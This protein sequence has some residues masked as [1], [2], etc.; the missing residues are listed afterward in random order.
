MSPDR[1][2][3]LLHLFEQVLSQAP[4]MRRTYLAEISS[5]DDD[6]R[7]RLEAML[8]SA[9]GSS[10]APASRE[11]AGPSSGVL[12]SMLPVGT[13]IGGYRVL[14][15]IARGG[16]GEVYL[17]VDTR[18]DRRVALK[19]L[20]QR[21]TD[22]PERVSRFQREARAA[23][24]LTHPNILTIHDFGE[25]DGRRFIASEFVEGRTL[26]ELIDAG[27]STLAETLEI[28]AQV[29]GALAAAHDAGIVHRDIK[30]ENLMV[31]PDG[32]VKVLDFGLAKLAEPNVAGDE[33]EAESSPTEF[34][35]R[36]GI[37]LGTVNYM[38][39][40]QAR[41]HKVDAR[42]DLFSLGVVL[43]ELATGRRPFGGVTPNHVLVAILDEEPRPVTDHL[44]E[45]PL[46]LQRIAGR[47][48]AKRPEERYGSAK[49][50][51]ADLRGMRQEL[52]GG[53]GAL[54]PEPAGGPA[55]AANRPVLSPAGPVAATSTVQLLLDR[56]RRHPA[57]VAVGVLAVA[58]IVVGLT[59]GLRR[60]PQPSGGRSPLNLD[61]MEVTR[62]TSV[63]GVLG[64][65]ISADGRF[66]VYD[67][68]GVDGPSL[69]LRDMA[70][71]RD[72]QL[73]PPAQ[74]S[75]RSF[76]LSRD[77]SS[78]FY[79]SEDPAHPVG[80]VLYRLPLAGGAPREII[81]GIIGM[82]F[83]PDG[84]RLLFSRLEGDPEIRTLYLANVDRGG[85]QAFA[86]GTERRDLTAFTWSPDAS[87]ITYLFADK[88]ADGDYWGV[89]EKPVSGGPERVVVAHH[90]QEIGGLAWLPDRSGLVMSAE[91]ET[92]GM[93]QL[94]HL[95][96]PDGV[97]SRI[98]RDLSNYG[99]PALTADGSALLTS[100]HTRP[101]R[102]WVAPLG[103]PGHARPLMMGTAEYGELA[104]T[105]DG[106]VVYVLTANGERNLWIMDAE[107]GGAR[108]L[109]SNAH[110]NLMPYVSPDGRSIVFV[111]NRTGD[112]RLW[113]IDL[114]GGHPVQ[115][116][117]HNAWAPQGSADGRW[118]VYQRSM[119]GKPTVW[120]VPLA[121]GTPVQLSGPGTSHPAIS[122]DGRWLA[123]EY[124]DESAHD[125]R[126]AVRPVEGG[127]PIAT[128]D[129]RIGYDTLR[130][131]PD[132]R[133]LVYASERDYGTVMLQPLE[134]GRPQETLVSARETLFAFALSP[135]GKR[136]AY[137]SGHHTA[138][139]I[140]F[141]NFR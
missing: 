117:D 120:R 134:T 140:L 20:P 57:T 22:H 21:V 98:T 102:I 12:R 141:R 54:R 101:A 90:R 136:I 137:T 124:L 44:P 77:D 96:Y 74:V 24:S 15:Q 135:D 108:Q 111:S 34:E 80:G 39:P 127:V 6:L 55:V 83:S 79:I 109:T 132:G 30:P 31:R 94:F 103:D 23:S 118:V 41:G 115:L 66:V 99:H 131:A 64:G 86:V 4:E 112:P 82:S 61:R 56:I 72:R 14:A 92:S 70:T 97:F 13:S 104:W 32:Y 68:A 91:D 42:S 59:L 129:L 58:A 1:P 37:V 93:M 69:W 114:D 65:C 48:L 123:Y 35:T 100:E 27:T 8:E 67:L 88:D 62:V 40:E 5:G 47:M 9:E 43:Y 36:A 110:A 53:V 133:G 125:R 81:V 113:R 16:M 2:P 73:V 18:L 139:L 138:D 105:P 26:R 51:L 7:R 10:A 52:E 63:G 78:L 29:A 128:F 89:M 95:S 17:A 76:A 25:H 85:E 33:V 122:P 130:W 121:G 75:Y 71:G 49:E 38:S 119:G 84:Q 107:G 87:A 11:R 19:L 50:L 106:R 116:T 45:A 28:V 60:W 46:E 3:E 126:V